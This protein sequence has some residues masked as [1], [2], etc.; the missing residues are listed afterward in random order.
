MSE[1]NSRLNYRNLNFGAPA[2]ERDIQQGLYDYFYENESYKN[3]QSGRKSVLLGNRGTGKSA[4]FKMLAEEY[5]K[6]DYIVIELAPEDYSYEIL[7]D[8][9]KGEIE[10]NWA[11]QGSF[12]A[13]WKYLL[14]IISMKK[15]IKYN[16][17]HI[18][19]RK[20]NLFKYLRD[21]HQNVEKNTLDLM[22][23]YL[24]RL[25]GIKLGSYE[26]G[27]KTKELQKLY[28]L[29]EIEG[30]LQ[31]LKLLCETK[32]IVILIDELDTGWD[33]SENA[34]AFV[35]G[36]F[37]AVQSINSL[38]TNLK[39]YIS[40]RKE[41]YENIPSLYEDSQKVIDLFEK[42]EWTEDSLLEMITRRI[43]YFYPNI[44]KLNKNEVW[45]L[46]FS[47]TLDYRQ[48]KSFNYIVDRT[49]YRPREIIQ[50]CTS[51]KDTS[52]MKD[53]YPP[54]NYQTISL[55]EYS[56]SEN[57]TKDIA[58]EFRFQYPGLLSIFETFRG[59]SYNFDRED[60]ELH[61]IEIC[62]GEKKIGENANWVTNLES[63]N[64]INALWS[65]GFL[66]AYA[67]GGQRGNRRRG[68]SY[69]GPHQVSNL[70]LKTIKKFHIHPMFR[71][72]LGLKEQKQINQ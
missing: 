41:L 64:L 38:T 54:I 10:G 27:I 50:F 28:K 2:A 36:L 47:E 33:A 61:C 19:K 69:L 67:I 58:A 43:R 3:L 39:V 8:V 49:L 4:I 23:S 46:V 32:P 18:N 24:K 9:L 26:A 25:E 30:L 16:S 71:A 53:F 31:E 37:Q 55:A 35:S 72:Y 65:V 21:N 45:N 51:I 57:R 7:N 48:N 22:T 68:S 40:L 62:I 1:E 70:N 52:I 59:V 63:D 66:R 60:L 56:Y 34:Q 6:K 5:K 11:K 42:L 14:Y 13:S 12:S 15:Q 20:S 29:E 44:E 17:Q